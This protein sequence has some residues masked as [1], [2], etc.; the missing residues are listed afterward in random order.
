MGLIIKRFCVETCKNLVLL[1]LRNG[2]KLINTDLMNTFGS[3]KKCLVG[4]HY[5][6]ILDNLHHW[7]IQYMRAVTFW[8]EKKV[9]PSKEKTLYTDDNPNIASLAASKAF[10]ISKPCDAT[11]QFWHGMDGATKKNENS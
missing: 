1:Q 9:W 2:S 11:Y 4:I 7:S 5:E 6:S 10:W 8:A 3:E